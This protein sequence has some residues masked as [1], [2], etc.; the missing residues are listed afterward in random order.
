MKRKIT[1]NTLIKFACYM[2]EN[3]KSPATLEKYLRDV[4]RFCTY[5]DGREIT[6]ALV[7]EYK[8]RL[9]ETHALTGA[10]SILAAV[11][12]LLRF[13]GR[14]ECCVKQFKI[15]KDAFCAEDRELTK[16]EYLSLVRTAER[17]NDLR[18]S[19]L[20]QTLCATGIRVSELKFIT[21]D[22]VKRGE[23]TV[24]CKGKTRRVFILPALRKKLLSYASQ[25]GIE[26]G[27]VFVTKNGRPL[28]RSNIWAEMK[29][30]CEQAGVCKNKVF[31]HNLRHLFA[32]TFYAIEKDVA[33]LADILGHS[34]LNTTRIYLLST[35]EEH[36]KKMENMRL[37][38]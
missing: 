24:S 20:I 34:N 33:K 21:V 37:I 16:G 15:Q 17:K 27:A 11:N 25:R 38:I 36:R 26:E 2:K 4:R 35:G 19:L 22:A 31:P 29:A 13:M 5:L 12:S 8:T 32:R 10:N 30:L 7:L 3:E 18:L 6:K 28:D 23:A 9:G 1:E 14:T